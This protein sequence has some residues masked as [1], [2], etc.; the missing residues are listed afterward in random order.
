[1]RQSQFEAFLL[2]HTPS[3]P[4]FALYCIAKP[5]TDLHEQSVCFD[6]EE[7]FQRFNQRQFE[8]EQQ[9]RAGT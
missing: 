6:S 8:I 4:D 7:E 9:L 5:L 2:A 3:N 1:M